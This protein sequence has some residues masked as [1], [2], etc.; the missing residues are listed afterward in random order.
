[1]LVLVGLYVRLNIT[2]TPQFLASLKSKKQVKMPVLDVLT[3][4]KRQLVVGTL[5]AVATFVLFYLMTV[6]TL[7]WAT[8]V[9]GYARRDFLLMQLISVLFFGLAVPFSAWLAD[10]FGRVITLI[11]ASLAIAVFGLCLSTLFDTVNQLQMT[12]FLSL[13]M[14]LMGMTYGPLGTILSELF[15]TEVRYTGASLTFNLAGILGASF[16]PFIAT[17]LAGNYGLAYVGFYLTGA[18]MLTLCAL[19]KVKN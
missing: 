19:L 2:E 10:R 9:L 16:A 3:K 12:L 6:F 5:I 14:A 4:Y 8:S 1:L 7:S 11:F 18:A 15:P 13:G 17:W